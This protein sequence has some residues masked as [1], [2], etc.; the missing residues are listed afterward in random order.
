MAVFYLL[1]AV[2]FVQ[3]DGPQTTDLVICVQSGVPISILT[4]V[5]AIKYYTLCAT[6]IVTS[7][8]IV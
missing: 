6:G 8:R 4:G 2:E 7:Q 5:L 3:I 1:S